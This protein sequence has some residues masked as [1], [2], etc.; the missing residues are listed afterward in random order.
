MICARGA[1]LFDF[2]REF[3]DSPK[4]YR[5][6]SLALIF[7]FLLATAVILLNRLGVIPQPFSALLPTNPF[8]S[9]RLAFSLVLGVEVIEMIIAIA[10]SVSLAVGKQ[11][12]IMALL[13]L[14]E[15]FTD[16]TLLQSKID[17]ARDYP[18]LLGIG[19]TALGGL[20]L[21]ALKGVF[22]QWRFTASK[23]D[24]RPY[25][26]AKK[27]AALLLLLVYIGAGIYDVYCMTVLGAP[28][29]F[30][31]I[32]YTALIFTDILLVLLGQYFMPCF[33]I[34]F[35]NSGYA[36]G[37]LLMRLSLAASQHYLGALLCVFAA[38]YILALTWAAYRFAPP[39]AKPE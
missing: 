22:A 27:T 2:L 34:T 33:H 11:L 25:I 7:S 1:Q 35:R 8:Q 29:V 19:A 17:I 21:F 24:A 9:I 16:I 12:E 10:D 18:I 23:R 31:K 6:I 5:T 4:V 14:R 20:T 28:A 36:V 15:T 26:R 38:L 32:F 30:F 13:L 3:W 39:E 37:T